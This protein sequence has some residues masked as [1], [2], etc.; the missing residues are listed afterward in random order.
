MVSVFVWQHRPFMVSVCVWQ[1]R[2]FMVL[3]YVCVC[4]SASAVN[5]FKF[6]HVHILTC[7]MSILNLSSY[8]STYYLHQG[9]YISSSIYR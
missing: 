3:V 4:L 6:S 1:L 7:R 9:L 5:G 8:L 2:P